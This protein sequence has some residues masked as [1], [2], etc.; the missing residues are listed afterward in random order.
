MP[1]AQENGW[2]E[3]TQRG[4]GTG[5]TVSGSRRAAWPK[6]SQKEETEK[7]PNG[8]TGAEKGRGQKA[9]APDGGGNSHPKRDQKHPRNDDKEIEN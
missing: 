9:A 6:K 1:G 3:T 4:H 7:T 5:R 2:E 8:E